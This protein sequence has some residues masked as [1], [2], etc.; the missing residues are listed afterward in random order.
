ME[1]LSEITER[2]RYYDIMTESVEFT[3]SDRTA[4]NSNGENG[5]HLWLSTDSTMAINRNSANK[6][7]G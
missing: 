6:E 7:E 4:S 2:I 1:D 3:C 5:Y